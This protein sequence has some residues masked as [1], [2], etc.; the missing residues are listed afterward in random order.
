MALRYIDSMGDHYTA[1]QVNQKWTTTAFVFRR[2]GVHGYAMAGSLFKGML[3]GS[4]TLILE[5]SIQRLNAG[6]LFGLSDTSNQKQISCEVGS[7]GVLS[8]ARYGSNPAADF[9]AQSAPD[10]IRQ[11]VWYHLGWRVTVHPSAGAVEIRVNGATVI[12]VSGI[13]T[14]ATTLP[15]SGAV[16]GFTLGDNGN[17]V[18]FDDLVV[19]DNVDDGIDD[20][21]LAGGGGFD[22][23]LGPVHIVVK[24]PDGAGVSAAW[25]PTPAGANW[26]NVDDIDHDTDATINTALA[27]AVGASDLF[28]M[29]DLAPIDDVVA[30]QSL[31]SARRQGDGVAT[32]AKL[33]H[34]AGV[35]TAG[36]A[37]ALPDTYNYII[38]PEPKT[39]SGLLW[40]RAR[41]NAI[42][43]GYRRLD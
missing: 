40:D 35:T 4:T 27:G 9:I 22:K 3:F 33:V 25:T 34:E 43:Y 6:A 26:Q 29:E 1:A 13:Q 42:Q 10:L 19:M 5:A 41:W 7:D 37:V 38:T 21:R 11:D 20:A 39:P 18:N 15:W 8:V 14:T 12:N 36:S 24:R 30:V 2:T 23:F 31:V 28:A 17:S 32:I 16:G